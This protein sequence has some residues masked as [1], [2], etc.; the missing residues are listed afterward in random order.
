M[1]PRKKRNWAM[2]IDLDRCTGCGACVVA[3]RAE[4]NISTVGSKEAAKGR[5]KH[6]IR[7]ERYW[8]GTFPN[9]RLRFMP[10]LCQHCEAAPCE[11]VCPTYASYHNEEGLNGQIYNRCIG[12]R[13]CANSCPYSV[14]FFNFFNPV[15]D[16]P[17]H[18]Q[19]NPDVSVRSVGI[20]EKC[21]FCLQRIKA[22]EAQAKAEGRALRPGEVTPACVQTCP[23]KAMS[24]GDLLDPKSTVSHLA[25]SNR[26]TRLLEHLGTKPKVIYLQRAS[27]HDGKNS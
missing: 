21:T 26:A 8:E 5:A 7:I 15:W 22:A 16:K 23:T 24:F 18:M 27:W 9:V 14:R 3:C 19:L 10:V 6:W 11:S 13:Y 2:A 17:L 1:E 25:E 20:M 4:N 12:T